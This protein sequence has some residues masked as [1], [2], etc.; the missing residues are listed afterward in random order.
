M[1]GAIA[2]EGHDS[3]I[4]AHFFRLLMYIWPGSSE[5]KRGVECRWYFSQPRRLSSVLE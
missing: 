2:G 5:T 4:D 1:V 3:V